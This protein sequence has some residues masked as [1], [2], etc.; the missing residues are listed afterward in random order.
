[1]VGGSFLKPLSLGQLWLHVRLESCLPV[2]RTETS[3]QTD[4]AMQG[5]PDTGLKTPRPSDDLCKVSAGVSMCETSPLLE[6]RTH[7]MSLPACRLASDV[8]IRHTGGGAVPLAR[9]WGHLMSPISFML[10]QRSLVTPTRTPGVF[11]GHDIST[12]CRLIFRAS[13]PAGLLCI[14]R[15]CIGH[16]FDHAVQR[17]P[18]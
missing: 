11:P 17:Y 3:C 18:Y 2:A 4:P 12:L 7:C 15:T 6:N 9:N 16:D 10:L 8:L 1:L 5:F 14:A 13:A